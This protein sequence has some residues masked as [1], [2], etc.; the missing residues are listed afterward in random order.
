[1]NNLF[2]VAG[3]QRPAAGSVQGV[4]VGCRKRVVECSRIRFYDSSNGVGE[5][6]CRSVRLIGILQTQSDLC[7]P[8]F[9]FFFTK[10]RFG[11]T[12]SKVGVAIAF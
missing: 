7:Q 9:G 2:F 11:F 12:I 6:K 10:Q 4:S 3:E 1:L 8:N 5:A